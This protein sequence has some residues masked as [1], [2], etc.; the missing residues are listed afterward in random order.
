MHTAAGACANASRRRA[1]AARASSCAG[2]GLVPGLE[3]IGERALEARVRVPER[4][5]VLLELDLLLLKL[6]RRL[7]QLGLLHLQL[8]GLLLQLLVSRGQL[9]GLRGE[10]PVGGGECR[11]IAARRVARPRGRPVRPAR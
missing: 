6:L 9:G 11:G 10:L 3:R 4:A 1:A 7:L 2:R 5:G 8:G